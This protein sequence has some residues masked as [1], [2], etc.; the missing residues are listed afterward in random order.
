MM[1]LAI[2]H[3]APSRS[4]NAQKPSKKIL[5]VKS[6]PSPVWLGGRRQIFAMRVLSQVQNGPKGC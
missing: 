4:E 3:G 1:F 5:G 6:G 2:Q